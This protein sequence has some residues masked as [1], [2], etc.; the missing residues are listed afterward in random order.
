MPAMEEAKRL[1]EKATGL[2]RPLRDR[3]GELVNSR[4]AETARFADDGFVP[5]HPRWPLVIYPGAVRLPDEFDPA[6]VFE[7]L[8]AANG[9]GSSWRNGVFD[10]THYH[11][12][13]HEVLGVARGSA[14]VQFGGD[15]GR[16]FRVSPGDVAILPAGTG[17]RRLSATP[18]FLIVGAYPP[19]GRYDLCRRREDRA[20][21]L[22]TIPNVPPPDADPVYGQGG[23]L[24][25]LWL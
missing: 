18:D 14:E 20:R 7:E 19:Q 2:A 10:F 3:L 16:W 23:P 4:Q 25:E 8:F 21:A 15:K 13:I 12:Q 5:N 24:L 1:V 9:W 6:A 17:H 11:S 22:Q